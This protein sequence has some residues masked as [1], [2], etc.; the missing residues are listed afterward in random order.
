MQD[1]QEKLEKMYLEE[2]LHSKGHTWTSV[3][4]LPE[5]ERKKIL[6]EAST[7]VSIKLAEMESKAHVIE[8]LHGTHSSD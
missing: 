3:A 7:Y 4:A 6:T 2:F 5:V 8:E 1:P